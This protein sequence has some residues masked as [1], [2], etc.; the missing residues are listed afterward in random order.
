M[1]IYF[2]EKNYPMEDLVLVSMFILNLVN[3]SSVILRKH[4]FCITGQV[5]LS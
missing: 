4:V 1:N 2:T 5:S 3:Y